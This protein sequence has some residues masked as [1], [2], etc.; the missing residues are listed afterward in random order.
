MQKYW[1]GLLL[2]GN[3]DLDCWEWEKLWQMISEV[4][5]LWANMD[6]I[7]FGLYHYYN[8]QVHECIIWI[9]WPFFY[10]STKFKILPLFSVAYADS[11]SFLSKLPFY[12]IL[13][14][15]RF[16]DI[17]IMIFISVD[18]IH[19]LLSCICHLHFDIIDC[20]LCPLTLKSWLR[21]CFR[22]LVL[23][24]VIAYVRCQ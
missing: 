15:V 19:M 5:E 18:Y 13:K 20:H 7:I 16:Y 12:D 22:R 1:K 2:L 4:L 23:A 14:E 17:L 6:F 11:A 8:V 10:T 9:V 3:R 21:H 24:D